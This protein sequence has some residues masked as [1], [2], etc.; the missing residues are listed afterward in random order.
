M[1]VT[2]NESGVVRR[3]A[4]SVAVFVVGLA[5]LALAAKSAS[6]REA[7]SNEEAA[8]AVATSHVATAL[9]AAAERNRQAMRTYRGKVAQYSAAMDPQRI[10]AP[11]G[12]AQARVA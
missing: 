4:W 5:I 9:W 6:M 1:A 2:G 11:E 12:A 8:H 3:T 7:R 10:V